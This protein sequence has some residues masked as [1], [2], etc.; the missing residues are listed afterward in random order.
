[1][2]KI[3]G[4]KILQRCIIKVMWKYLVVNCVC[5][6]S[7]HVKI[8]KYA[9]LTNYCTLFATQPTEINTLY[10]LIHVFCGPHLFAC[11]LGPVEH[12]LPTHQQVLSI[13]F[14][15]NFMQISVI[16]FILIIGKFNIWYKI[17]LEENLCILNWKSKKFNG[18]HNSVLTV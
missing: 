7:K 18:T 3:H 17:V 11:W 6:F 10:S 13:R 15:N 8:Y 2:A 4:R 1:M 16:L 14:E 5:N 9:D 12:A